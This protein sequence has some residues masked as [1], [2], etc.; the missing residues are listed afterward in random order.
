M[1][2]FSNSQKSVNPSAVLYQIYIFAER[3]HDMKRGV[4]FAGIIILDKGRILYHLT[5]YVDEG[6]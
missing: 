2:F 6:N 4:P 3:A 1:F 5:K